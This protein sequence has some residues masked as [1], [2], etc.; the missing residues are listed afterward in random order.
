MTMNNDFLTKF[1]KAPRPE[2]AASLYQRIS[3]PMNTQTKHQPLRFVALTLSLLAVLIAA[4]LLSPSV[5]AF[6]QG[7]IRQVGGYVFTQD[8]S[9]DQNTKTPKVI[10][11]ERTQDSVSIHASKNIPTANN[12]AEASQLAGF[13]VL[14]PTYLPHGYTSMS[15]WLITSEGNGTVV[16]NG[17][18]SGNT[19]FAINQS[20]YR[21]G[22][23]QETYHRDQIVDVTVRG[24]S[25][26]WLPAPADGKKALVW[27]ENGINYSIISNSLSLDEMLKI[28]ASLS[29]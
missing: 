10:S 8:G 6:A 12:P 13:T 23:P 20:K 26:V 19:F 21:A 27:E 2:F 17:Y 15:G 1:R 5:R 3:K 25:G 11:I 18:N 22:A 7:F 14:A 4:L 16:T 29:Q 28:A 24:Q 9:I